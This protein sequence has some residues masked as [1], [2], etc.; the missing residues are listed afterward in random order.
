M[1]ERNEDISLNNMP[2][3][4]RRN[5]APSAVGGYDRIPMIDVGT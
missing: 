5:S 4:Q 1:D 3:R 2:R